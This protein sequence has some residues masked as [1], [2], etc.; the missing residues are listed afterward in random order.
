[1]MKSS[2]F[3]FQRLDFQSRILFGLGC[4]ILYSLWR[5]FKD[6][7]NKPSRSPGANILL[8]LSNLN[9][10]KTSKTTISTIP[11]IP[12]HKITDMLSITF[13]T[14]RGTTI[15]AG[16]AAK[17]T[18]VGA[19]RAHNALRPPGS[20]V[21]RPDA[22]RG[23]LGS[24]ARLGPGSY[25]PPRP[26]NRCMRRNGRHLCKNPAIVGSP[27]RVQARGP[28]RAGSASVLDRPPRAAARRITEMI[29]SGSHSTR[30]HTNQVL[31]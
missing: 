22:R 23:G 7:Q 24:A 20:A 13:N 15:R 2:F 17:Q 31:R 28:A 1:M 26:G 11:P 25:G 4:L 29:S 3:C 14:T 12:P 6:Y 18:R 19:R 30:S 8:S 10:A 5:T 21:A 27:R 16:R 9:A